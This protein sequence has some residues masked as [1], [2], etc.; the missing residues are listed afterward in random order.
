MNLRRRIKRF[1]TERIV[2]WLREVEQEGRRN[3]QAELMSRAKRCG[4]DLRLLGDFVITGIENAEIGDNVHIGAN[5]YIRAEG[6]LVIGDHAHFSRNLVIYTINHNF[7]GL[8]LPY[9]ETMTSKP[10]HIGKNVWI[11]MNVCI[12]PGTIIGDG[13]IIGM[14][15]TVSGEV[16]PLAIIGGQKWRQLSQRDAAHYERLEAAGEYG[17]VQGVA[18]DKD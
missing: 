3:E 16:P 6:G 18:L 4:S 12:A 14:G 17:G 15:A 2:L 11:G 8:R 7:N 10:V 13:A 5:C 1:L 9:D